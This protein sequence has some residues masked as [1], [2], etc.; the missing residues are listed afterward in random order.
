MMNEADL[1]DTGM[2]MALL[3]RFRTQ[4]L[5]RALKIKERV[6]QG[7]RLEDTDLTF[8]KEVLESADQIKGLVDRHPEYQE[9]YSRS[10]ELYHA[11]TTRALANEES[12]KTRT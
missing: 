1:K 8:L 12:G 3:E 5:P 9:I 6:D 4:R 11:I 10:V 2:A 7:E